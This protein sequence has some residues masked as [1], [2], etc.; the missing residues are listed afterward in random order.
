[1][2]D[3]E[4]AKAMAFTAGQLVG[5]E[6]FEVMSPDGSKV[7]A[8]PDATLT[9][10]QTTV[11]EEYDGP[12]Q[13]DEGEML[14]RGMAYYVNRLIW[15]IQSMKGIPSAAATIMQGHPTFQI[16]AYFDAAHIP[17]QLVVFNARLAEDQDFLSGLVFGDALD[18]EERGYY[19]VMPL[20]VEVSD[21]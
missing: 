16:R 3:S 21:E 9:F 18:D 6:R 11:S 2:G 12:G 20:H 10:W 1:M 17:Y 13:T 4:N 15:Q 8:V 19:S 7:A 14:A 5:Y